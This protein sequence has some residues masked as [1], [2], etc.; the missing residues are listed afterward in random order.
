MRLRFNDAAVCGAN[1]VLKAFAI[2]C[3]G[4]AAPQLAVAQT[5]QTAVPAFAPGMINHAQQMRRFPDVDHGAQPAPPEIPRFSVNPDESGAVATFQ[6]GGATFTNN[7][8]FFQNLG[9]NGRD[10]FTCH[11]P[12]DG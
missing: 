8:A 4:C 6:A 3:L 2:V 5:A 10:C 9:T 7:N 1:R 12:Q 11:Q